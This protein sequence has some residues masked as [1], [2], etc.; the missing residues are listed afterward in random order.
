MSK[1]T[2]DWI[3][4]QVHFWYGRYCWIHDKTWDDIGSTLTLRDT[5]TIEDTVETMRIKDFPKWKD[6][7]Y[8][9]HLNKIKQWN[10]IKP[11]TKDHVFPFRF[12]DNGGHKKANIGCNRLVNQGF[13][14]LCIV[15]DMYERYSYGGYH[16][17]PDT[18]PFEEKENKVHFLGSFTGPTESKVEGPWWSMYKTCRIDI[19]SKWI[20]AGDWV[21]VGLIDKAMPER[22]RTSPDYETKIVPLLKPRIKF[23]E[24]FKNKYILC[25]EGNDVSSAFSWALA[26]N[27][28]PIHTYPYTS[29]SLYNNGLQPYVHF[30]PVKRDASDLRE[31]YE[32]C[33]ANQDKCKEIVNNGR[34]HM[35]PMQDKELCLKVEAEFVKKWDLQLKH[36]KKP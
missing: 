13:G 29:E 3:R 22:V 18:I 31:A 10:E 26:S 7:R 19:V 32:W 34:E 35:K 28:V 1:Y 2:D 33:E 17:K 16:G 27:C 11:F 9:M 14:M 4:A 24:N 21:D 36:I 6:E 23:E 5:L 15:D 25:I 8:L 30:V 12:V 20:N